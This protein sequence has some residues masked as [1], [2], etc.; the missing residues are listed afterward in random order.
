MLQKGQSYTA[1]HL[2]ACY[3][4][5]RAILL[6]TLWDVTE[7]AELYCYTPYGMLQKG[8]SY[9]AKHLMAC[10]RKGRA[11]PLHTLWH[12]TERAELYRY[13]PYGTL[14]KGQSYTATHLTACYR[15]KFTFTSPATSSL[16][17]VTRVTRSAY[18]NGYTLQ[19]KPYN[20]Q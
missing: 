20:F 8:Q 13:T 18:Q 19:L 9:T 3:R 1:T 2:K 15:A 4:K 7:R 16:I 14:Q 5:G 11:I 10:Y 6:Y 17:K 12:V